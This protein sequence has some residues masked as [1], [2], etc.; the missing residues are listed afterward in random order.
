MQQLG[1]Q[2]TC[3]TSFTYTYNCQYKSDCP[4]HLEVKLN[5]HVLAKATGVVVTQCLGVAKSLK[6]GQRGIKKGEDG[7]GGK[8][9]TG[10]WRRW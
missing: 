7:L 9:T 2:K 1:R 4:A 3:W 10:E 5:I 8:E 6:E